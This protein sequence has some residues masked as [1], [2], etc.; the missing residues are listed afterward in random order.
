MRPGAIVLELKGIITPAVT[1]TEA[2]NQDARFLNLA[3]TAR[4]T[5]S[6]EPG[7]ETT[8]GLRLSPRPP[9]RFHTLVSS[10]AI[11]VVASKPNKATSAQVTAGNQR[12]CRQG[13][14]LKDPRS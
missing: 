6:G 3:L 2:A 13:A 7:V 11:S 12:V 4:S 5:E 9:V 8:F 14:Q 10:A 1:R